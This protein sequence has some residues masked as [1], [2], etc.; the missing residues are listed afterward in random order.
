MPD[1]V[2]LA[3][4][5]LTGGESRRFGAP[6]ADAILAGASLREIA[7]K[8]LSANCTPIAI[9][10]SPAPQIPDVSHIS[11]PTDL[12]H[13]PLTG[14]L[15]GLEWAQSQS[16]DWLAVSPCDMPLLPRDIHDD[17]LRAAIGNAAPIS[18]ITDAGGH[19]PLCSV[20][21]T[22]LAAQ[23]RQRLTNGHPSIWRYAIELGATT[24][25]LN[26]P[27]QT[28]NINTP[29]DLKRAA[30]LHQHHWWDSEKN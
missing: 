27:E 10:G 19:S 17:L 14:I 11:D 2:P 24:L 3:G 15:A 8:R 1:N 23:V 5:L 28:L 18:M 29:S 21:S 7:L 13:G 6:K 20:W 30:S 12:P 25:P 4:L 22:G 9:A 26:N 16:I